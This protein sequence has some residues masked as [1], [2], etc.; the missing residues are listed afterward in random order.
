MNTT[1]TVSSDMEWDDKEVNEVDKGL[2]MQVAQAV[3]QASK[4]DLALYFPDLTEE[5]IKEYVW[6]A[7]L[8]AST[9]MYLGQKS[10][11]KCMMN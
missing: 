5:E 10:Y 7:D 1:E 8:A 4:A 11:G 6:I 9:F 2:V 3:V